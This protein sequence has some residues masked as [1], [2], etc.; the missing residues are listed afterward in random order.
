MKKTFV[1]I[2]LIAVVV[3]MACPVFAAEVDPV[4]TVPAADI[5]LD[6]FPTIFGSFISI[7]E[8]PPMIYLFSIFFLAFVL[9]IF[10]RITHH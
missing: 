3:S 6:F 7:F 9:L 4:V 2:S 8:C 1:V 10:M 5:M